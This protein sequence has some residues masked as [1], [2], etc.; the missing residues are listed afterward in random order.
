MSETG[1]KI[2]EIRTEVVADLV[3][4]VSTDVDIELFA[5]CRYSVF[6]GL[7]WYRRLLVRPYPPAK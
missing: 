3:P 7:E 2:E 5:R 4:T 1:E 6:R